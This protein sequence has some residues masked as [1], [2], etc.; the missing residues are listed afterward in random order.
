M[1]IFDMFDGLCP[2]DLPLDE[3]PIETKHVMK[4]VR[5]EVKATE[6]R[7]RH[8]SRALRTALIAAAM[9]AFLGVTAY[10]AY[11]FFIDKYVIDQPYPFE[12]EEE[13]ADRT[14][15][16]ISL[17]GYQGTPEY[18]AYT[19]WEAYESDWWEKAMEQD[20]WQA[21]GV[22]DSWHETPDNYANLYGAS[23]QDQADE[24]DAIVEK[25]GLTLHQ[26]MA[27]YYQAK[28]LY[29]ALGTEPFFTGDIVSYTEDYDVSGYVYDD[30]SFKAEFDED[31]SGDRTVGI[32]MF[33]N[34]KG[35]FATIS[36]VTELTEDCEAWQ[37]TTKSGRSV[38]LYLAPR[39]AEIMTESEG[40]Y[41]EAGVLSGSAPS[42]DPA[43]DPQLSEEQKQFYLEGCLLADP[44]M[45]EAEQE[46]AWQDFYDMCVEREQAAL[47]PAI[48]KA[49]LETIAD[50]IDFAALADRFDG[51]AHPETAGM[52]PVLKEREAER[53]APQD[54][55]TGAYQA[56]QEDVSA[57]AID[58]AEVID[59]LGIFALT[60][61]EGYM[62]AFLSGHR[63]G[64]ALDWT[65]QPVGDVVTRQY[66]GGKAAY[67]IELSWYRFYPDEGRSSSTTAEV[68]E[69]ARE[70]YEGQGYDLSELEVNG[71]EGFVFADEPWGARAA[72]YDPERDLLFMLV[73]FDA[74]VDVGGAAELAA[75]VGE[76]PDPQPTPPPAGEQTKP[77]STP[78]PILQ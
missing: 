24:L 33:V 2:D 38:D 53:F 1:D 74:D 58:D 42:Y 36:G 6:R 71:C 77:L 61:P 40:A 3:S 60:P 20:P 65:E 21:R 23:F 43:K 5:A 75:T 41:M 46:A 73:A 56:E 15:A 66:M 48:T 37:Y 63:L 29:E 30:G 25:Y 31:L 70:F 16:R 39:S 50:S 62:D 67:L 54:A 69:S 18:Q 19:E 34:A 51:T 44:D 32:Q 14:T 22:D 68:L 59:E 28:D 64:H 45:T 35:S 7:P 78:I 13:A 17:T 10:A 12:T 4:L 57:A 26:D 9:A 27:A 11:E 8:M 49:D 55:E 72:W 47:P 52:L 76:Q